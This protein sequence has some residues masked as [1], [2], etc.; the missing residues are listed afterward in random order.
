MFGAVRSDANGDQRRLAPKG[1]MREFVHGIDGTIIL[2]PH[3]TRVNKASD[4]MEFVSILSKSVHEELVVQST[5][6]RMEMAMTGYSVTFLSP[7]NS[8]TSS[9]HR[10]T[11]S[12]LMFLSFVNY[13]RST[14]DTSYQLCR[15]VRSCDITR[16]FS[17]SEHSH[18][19]TNK[20]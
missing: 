15:Y 14:T 10:R 6:Y 17:Q 4:F 7:W 13:T 19:N 2:L 20:Y 5:R 3:E 18:A 11:C 9:S 8:S 16:R 12:F 1:I